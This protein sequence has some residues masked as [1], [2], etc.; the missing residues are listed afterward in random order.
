MKR[1]L[2]VCVMAA[3]CVEPAPELGSY[4]QASLVGDY[5]TSTCSTAVVLELSRQI[6]A[7]VGCLSP[8]Q[9]VPFAEGGNIVFTGSAVLPYISEAARVDL[10]AAAADGAPTELRIT[11]GYRT[12]VQQ[13][14][15]WRWWQLGRCGITAAAEPGSSNHESG[16]A[17][18]VS[19]YDA[20]IATLGAHRWDHSVP[21]DPVHFD[22]LASPDIRGTDVLAFQRLWNRN[23]AGDVIDEDGDWG[24]QTEA[25][26]QAATAEGFPIGAMCA[27]AELDVAVELVEAPRVM[28][29]G[30]RGVVHVVLRNTGATWPAGTALVTAEPA[31][32]ASP[33]ADG[34]SWPAADRPAAQDGETAGGAAW[35][36]AFAVIAPAG[37]GEYTESFAL[38]AGGQR[39]GTIAF[40]IQVDRDR[41]ASSGGC[42]AGGGAARAASLIPLLGVLV[43]V[44]R[45]RRLKA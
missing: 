19:N 18:D 1:A 41:G 20:W 35:D 2:A 21:G 12:V 16:R 24:P 31:G 30:E 42:D 44:T 39:F 25:R 14:L 9:L 26:V 38:D 7:E 10:A 23:N 37:D 28:A 8:G 36:V 43:I 11:S 3:A 29:P 27:S 34:E 6:A 5:E 33:F 17:L 32:R 45:R 4:A 40:V 15:L 13:Y 22:H